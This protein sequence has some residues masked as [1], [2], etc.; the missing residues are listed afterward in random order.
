MIEQSFNG[1]D[2]RG[3]MTITSRNSF[4]NRTISTTVSRW[5]GEQFVAPSTKQ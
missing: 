5:N 1:V 4:G 2:E 3:Y